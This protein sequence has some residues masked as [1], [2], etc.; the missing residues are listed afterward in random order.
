MSGLSNALYLKILISIG[1]LAIIAVQ[2]NWG[3]M[4]P[5]FADISVW[6]LGC[7]FV[8]LAIQT[9]ILGIRWY[10]IVNTGRNRMNYRTA[11]QITFAAL[12]ANFIFLTSI[13]GL[14][15]RVIL[16]VRQKISLLFALGASL[17]DR[18]MTIL[19]LL[20]LAALFMP[21]AKVHMGAEL[22][23]MIA[24]L[25]GLFTLL[26]VGLFAFSKTKH[27][28]FLQSSRKVACTIK[29]MQSIFVKPRLFASIVTVSLIAQLF[30]FGAVYILMQHAG[31]EVEFVQL[32]TVLPMIAIVASL[33]IGIGGWGVREGAFVYGLGLLGVGIEDAFIVSIQI[34]LLGLLSALLVGLPTWFI[35]NRKPVKTTIT[36]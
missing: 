36:L 7:A 16:T 6:V 11:L 17:I 2:I 8:M 10:L 28:S 33:P 34:G 31:I 1:L 23:V 5:S 9:L 30:Y 12:I 32:L 29:H 25:L 13:S 4:S 24:S 14:A 26:L 3:E 22:S 18:L 21:L 27:G 19:A 35:Q 20:I 15:V